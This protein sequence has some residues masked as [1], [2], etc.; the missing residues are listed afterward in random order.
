MDYGVLGLV[1][2]LQSE[3]DPQLL[4]ERAEAF[5]STFPVRHLFLEVVKI[6]NNDCFNFSDYFGVLVS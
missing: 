1:L 5:L 2:I 3:K 4:D 6:D